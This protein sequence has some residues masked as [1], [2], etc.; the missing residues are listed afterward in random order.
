MQ[1]PI[2]NQED[3]NKNP[4][5]KNK[6]VKSSS[7]VFPQQRLKIKSIA[8]FNTNDNLNKNLAV[9]SK[10]KNLLI[11]KVSSPSTSTTSLMKKT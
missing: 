4:T 8:N 2:L 10:L 9:H 6:V 3:S 5:P 7:I 1:R 11:K